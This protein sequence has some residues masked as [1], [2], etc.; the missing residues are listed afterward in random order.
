MLR[1]ST[2]P[3]MTC[4]SASHHLSP[5]VSLKEGVARDC[6]SAADEELGDQL[7]FKGLLFTGQHA[8]DRAER[9]VRLQRSW[10]FSSHFKDLALAAAGRRD[11]GGQAV[12]QQKCA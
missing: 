10:L 6:L 12:L 5:P 7:Q 2:V 4:R 9:P 8:T 1:V 11:L 3:P